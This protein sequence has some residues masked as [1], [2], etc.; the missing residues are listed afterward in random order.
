MVSIRRPVRGLTPA[1]RHTT[2]LAQC[3]NPQARAG[4]D[5][6]DLDITSWADVSIRRPVRGLTRGSTR[7]NSVLLFQSAGPCGA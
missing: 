2:R 6:F 4:P 7:W 5:R 1:G 3:F